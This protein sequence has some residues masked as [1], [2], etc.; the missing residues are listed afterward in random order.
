MFFEMLLA[1]GAVYGYR[2]FVRRTPVTK[3]QTMDWRTPAA[4]AARAEAAGMLGEKLTHAKLRDSLGWCCG[5]EFYLHDGSVIIEHAPGT[6]YPTIEIDHLAITPFGVFIFE[7]KNWSGLIQP[8]SNPDALLRS[9]GAIGAEERKSPIAQN[10]SKLAFLRSVLPRDWHVAG[11][12][13]FSSSECR[14]SADLD[15]DLISLAEIPFW[16]RHQRQ[17]A[18][19]S[20]ID[21]DMARKAICKFIDSNPNALIEHKQRIYQ[22]ELAMSREI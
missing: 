20:R 1:A 10:R 22:N 4:A 14:L 13:V 9:T 6:R 16:I 7:T 8:S 5:P 18:G 21:I 3:A 2:R 12:G 15:L 19:V 17:H 11:A